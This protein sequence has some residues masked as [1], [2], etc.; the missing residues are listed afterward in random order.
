MLL[1]RHCNLQLKHLKP[2]LI[3]L[4]MT[5]D[6]SVL[7]NSSSFKPQKSQLLIFGHKPQIGKYQSVGLFP[8]ACLFLELELLS[9]QTL[10]FAMAHA[11]TD[12]FK[13]TIA[14]LKPSCE[15]RDLLLV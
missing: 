8:Y 15:H 3:L 14:P 13:L 4:R 1:Q 9:S 7:S 6:A 12:D 10:I 11:N 2:F 5:Y